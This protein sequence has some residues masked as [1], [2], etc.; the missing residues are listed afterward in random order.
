MER[1]REIPDVFDV[2]AIGKPLLANYCLL[3][4]E[5]DAGSYIYMISDLYTLILQNCHQADCSENNIKFTAGG[6][7]GICGVSC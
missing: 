2:F 1:E 7:H 3:S 5:L 4:G 6:G